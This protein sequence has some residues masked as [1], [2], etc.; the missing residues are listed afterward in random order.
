MYLRGYAPWLA[1]LRRRRSSTSATAS[2][3]LAH[4]VPRGPFHLKKPP[5]FV[6]TPLWRFRPQVSHG[7][8]GF[9]GPESIGGRFVGIRRVCLVAII[10]EDRACLVAIGVRLFLRYSTRSFSRLRE[11]ISDVALWVRISRCRWDMGS[12]SLLGIT[13]SNFRQLC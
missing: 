6:A 2:R 7:P 8:I 13:K 11:A 3:C 10:A 5:S 12:L 4:E 1:R 9:V